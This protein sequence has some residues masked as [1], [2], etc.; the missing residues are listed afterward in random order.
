MEIKKLVEFTLD[1]WLNRDFKFRKLP[2]TSIFNFSVKSKSNSMIPWNHLEVLFHNL[3]FSPISII[4]SLSDLIKFEETSEIS[5]IPYGFDPYL[6]LYPSI[7]D[8]FIKLVSLDFV[9]TL[10]CVQLMTTLSAMTTLD[11]FDFP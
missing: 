10:D 5:L 8:I 6:P 1:F 9:L 3:P 2:L 7:Q 4:D 11:C